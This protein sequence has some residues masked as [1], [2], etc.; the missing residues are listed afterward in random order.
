[1]IGC[2]I[3]LGSVQRT[4]AGRSASFGLCRAA[5]ARDAR[6]SLDHGGARLIVHHAEPARSGV[7][8]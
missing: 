4:A 6:Q 7:A 2:Q 1:M 8:A 5:A 3:A